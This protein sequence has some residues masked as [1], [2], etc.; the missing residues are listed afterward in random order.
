MDKLHFV[1]VGGIG[2][3]GLA[4]WCRASGIQ[5]TGSDR[6]AEKAENQ[7]LLNCLRRE[8]I[9]IVPQDGSFI[10]Y[11]EPDAVVYS[12]AIEEDNPD[13]IAAKDIPRL[14]RSKLLETM[15]VEKLSGKLSVAVAGSCG[16][17]T[18]TA[19]TAEAL[20][21]CGDDAGMLNGALSKRFASGCCAGNFR[22]GTGKFFVF[23][24]DESDKSLLN[25]SPDYAIVL[26]LGTDHYS[27]EEL[28]R[29]FAEFLNHVKRGAVVERAVYEAVK[30]MLC[31][32]LEIRVFDREK[33]P[34]SRYWLSDYHIDRGIPSAQF[35]EEIT[36]TLPA[37]GVHSAMNAL[38]IFALLEMAGIP[39]PQAVE[40]LRRFDGIRRRNDFIGKTANGAPVYDDYAHNPEKI[41]SCL[42]ALAELVPGAVH[43]VFQPHGFGPLGF[44]RDELFAMLEKRLRKGDEFWMLPPYYAGGTSSFKP[45]SQEVVADWRSRS[46]MPERYRVFESRDELRKA[47]LE[48]TGADDLIVIL[49]ARDNSLPEFAKSLLK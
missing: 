42:E 22:A 1:G 26:N 13:F 17:S 32:N 7:S 47:L 10:R 9:R 14:H 25:Y 48:R 24:A 43:A 49:G 12:S 31:G 4:A 5:V 36:L 30:P 16:K 35:N 28:A 23:E 18:V 21:N 2:M 34:D 37:P 40:S 8:G 39:R 20:L 3:S 6:G 38:A 27:K 33:Q 11:G 29:V 45:T 46:Q 41:S 19:Y 44:F 15:I